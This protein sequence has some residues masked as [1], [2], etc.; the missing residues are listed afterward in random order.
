MFLRLRLFRLFNY[1]TNITQYKNASDAFFRIVPMIFELEVRGIFY[2]LGLGH[3]NK[4]IVP[5]GQHVCTVPFWE[6][7]K[8]YFSERQWG[9]VILD[10]TYCNWNGSRHALHSSYL[11]AAVFV[12]FLMDFN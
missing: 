10:K 3:I 4:I 6:Q 9:T 11:L 5:N 1:I 12:Y 7:V 2:T 8:F